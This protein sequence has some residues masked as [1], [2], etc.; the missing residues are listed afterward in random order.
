MKF[1]KLLSFVL[2][3]ALLT[4]P[5]LSLS[6]SAASTAFLDQAYAAGR[7]VKTT[8]T[9]TPGSI[10]ATDPNMS[11][12]ADLLKVLKIETSSQAQGETVLQQFDLFLQNKSSLNLTFLTKSE[13]SH[14]LSSLL[15]GKVLSFTMEE[16]FNLYGLLLI[17]STE[18]T[19]MDPSQL[20]AYREYLKT[21]MVDAYQNQPKDF[22]LDAESYITAMGFDYSKNLQQGRSTRIVRIFAR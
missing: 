20:E 10:F 1:R 14:I 16:F 7:N 4:M 11:L 3:L 9:F 5:A 8:V 12:A 22:K 13:E 17:S 19:S 2:A 21:T 6:E 15:G 18:S